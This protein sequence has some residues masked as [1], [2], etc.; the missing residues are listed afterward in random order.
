MA[1]SS[2]HESTFIGNYWW[3]RWRPSSG[4]AFFFFY[5]RLDI[6][7]TLSVVYA[8]FGELIRGQRK[9]GRRVAVQ[10]P[11]SLKKPTKTAFLTFVK[12]LENEKLLLFTLSSTIL[13]LFLLPFVHG[14]HWSR[15]PNNVQIFR[16]ALKNHEVWVFFK[17]KQNL[18][19]SGKIREKSGKNLVK[20][21]EKSGKKSGKIRGKFRKPGK[22]EKKSGKNPETGNNL[23]NWFH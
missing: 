23:K 8:S 9:R 20:I 16:I 11:R 17:Q 6:W 14:P 13:L 2:S 5:R 10:R 7:A 3:G 21:R 18:K 15:F 19:N 4:L 12:A 1:D 22:S